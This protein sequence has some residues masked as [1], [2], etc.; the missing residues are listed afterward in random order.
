MEVQIPIS[1]LQ[2]SIILHQHHP[3]SIALPIVIL[4][5]W[6][7]TGFE[8]WKPFIEELVATVKHP[9][10][11]IPLPGMGG[12]PP[13][14]TVWGAVEYAQYVS[15]CLEKLEISSCIIVGHSFGGCIGSIVAANNPFLVKHLVLLAP[16]IVRTPAIQT[17][18]QLYWKKVLGLPVYRVFQRIWRL[19]KGSYDYRKNRGIMK[20]IYERIIHE[21]MTHYLPQISCPLTIFWGDQDT[22]TPINQLEIIHNFYPSGDI[23]ILHGVNHGIH[24]HAIKKVLHEIG[25]VIIDK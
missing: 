22:Y 10:Y 6:N 25:N 14:K 1:N 15:E 8:S 24:I 13:P 16:A 11:Q 23:Q 3:D 21:D 4:H 2:Q 12:C 18:R 20:N 5:G 7:T 19:A 17:P 9:I